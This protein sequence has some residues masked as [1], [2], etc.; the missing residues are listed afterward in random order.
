MSDIRHHK[1]FS[2]AQPIKVMFDVRP[3]IPVATNLIGYA[4]LLTNKKITIFSHGQG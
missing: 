3:A 2:S 1:G 4:L